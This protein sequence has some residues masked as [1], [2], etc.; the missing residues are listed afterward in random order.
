MSKQVR[1][2][3]VTL[4]FLRD[5]QGFGSRG[6]F[7]T[8]NA[9]RERILASNDTDERK[10]LAVRVFGEF[11]AA[12]ED[13]GGLCIAIR[14]RDEDSGLIYGYLTYGPTKNAPKTSLEKL[15]ELMMNENAL[16]SV[17]RL[18]SLNEILQADPELTKTLLPQLYAETKTILA[19]VSRLYLYDSKVFVRIY[20]KTKH[21][22]VVI[23][24][25]RIFDP[26]QENNSVANVAWVVAVN[27]DYKPNQNS[28]HQMVE[29]FLAE[30]SQINLF[31][32][33]IAE[34]RGAVRVLCELTALLIEQGLITCKYGTTD[35]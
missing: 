14:H 27:P 2:N 12:L 33:R 28:K 31:V 20:N 32:D 4:S 9:L 17:L 10:L 16:T 1:N 8:A 18:P 5:Y 30:E 35:S 24:D 3:S 23:S 29:L 6:H 22:F 34:I 19:Q 11:I 21:G 15:F 25:E 26:N 13:L 7:I